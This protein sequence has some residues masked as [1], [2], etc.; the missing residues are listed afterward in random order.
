MRVEITAFMQKGGVF[1]NNK[2]SGIRKFVSIFFGAI[3][4]L[5]L[6]P[7]MITALDGYE[8]VESTVLFV[9]FAAMFLA[10]ADDMVFHISEK[11]RRFIAPIEKKY[12]A[13]PVIEIVG[14]AFG[15]VALLIAV[16][17]SVGG[18]GIDGT[19]VAV[20]VILLLV[21]ADL[22]AVMMSR[23][24]IMRG[25]YNNIGESSPYPPQYGAMPYSPNNPYE[26]NGYQP[27]R[28]PFQ[29]GVPQFNNQNGTISNGY[30]NPN[31][32]SR[33]ENPYDIPQPNRNPF[34]PGVP[35]FNNQNGTISNGYANPNQ[36]SRSEN[37]Y[38]I[39]QPNENPYQQRA[40]QN[41][42]NGNGTLSN[43][44]VSLNKDSQSENPYDIPQPNVS[45]YQTGAAP[46]NN[47]ESR[48]LSNGHVSLNKGSQSENPY[49]IPQQ[50]NPSDTVFYPG[51][52]YKA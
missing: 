32:G 44:H 40:P 48:S 52:N 10:V 20:T 17:M 43:G 35:Q 28:N 8:V 6:I 4:V 22:V 24:S 31:Q 37:P 41:N 3:S 12:T 5:I 25:K 9:V 13:I 23:V 7:A 39:P 36:G 2:P 42:N 11:Y 33:S 49:D 19:G 51:N 21:F 27:N 29:P 50:N 16:T 38:D 15:L 34:Q 47:N 46:Q 30:A 1:L 45:P 26:M 18:D 14:L